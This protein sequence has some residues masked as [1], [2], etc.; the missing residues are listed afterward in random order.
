LSTGNIASAPGP[1]SNIQSAGTTAWTGDAD[2]EAIILAA[3]GQPMNSRNASKLEFDFIPLSNQIS[4]NFIFA[5]EEYGTFQCT[6]SDAFAFLLT[7]TTTNVTTNLAVIPNTTIP[8]S[9]VTIRNAIYNTGCASANPSYFGSYYLLPQGQNPI[10]APVNFNGVT[11]PMV[12]T[13]TVIPGQTYHI[14]LVVADRS[15]NAYDSAVFLEGG[16]FDIGNIQLGQD[17]LTANG[18]ALCAGDSYTIQSGLSGPNYTYVWTKDG[19]VIPN[20]TNNTLI[21]TSSGVYGLSA[22]YTGTTCTTSDAVTIQ[23]YPQIIAPTPNN[24][25][26]CN[27]LGYSEFNLATNDASSLGTLDPTAFTVSYFSSQADAVANVNSLPNLFTNTVQFSQTLYARVTNTTSGCF[28][29]N[30]FNLIVQD[31]TPQFTISPDFSICDGSTGTIVVTPIN[32]NNS[33]VIYSWTKDGVALTDT[34]NSIPISQSGVYEVTIN[35]MGCTATGTT[36]V[37]ITPIPIADTPTNV[38]VCNSYILPNLT[39]GNYYTG[40]NGSGTALNAG[41]VVSTSQVIYVFAQSGTIPNCTAQNSFTITINSITA[42]AIQNVIACTSYTL[43]SLNANNNYYT[44]TNG[45]GT[46]LAA[47]SSITNSQTL[48][49]YA[50]TGTSPNCTNESSFSITILV[51]PTLPNFNNVAACVSYVLPTLSNGNYFSQ[52]NGVGPIAQGS[53]ITT[54]QTVY[55]YSSVGTAPT[56]C[57]AEKQFDVTITNSPIFTISGECV[58]TNFVLTSELSTASNTNLSY[59]WKDQNDVNL[60]TQPT[61]I[62]SGNGNYSLVVQVIGTNCSR[63]ETF[64]ANETA[65]TI[66]KGISPNNDGLNDTFDLTGLGIKELSIY[67]RYGTKVYNKSN[68]SNEWFG[69]TNSGKELPDGTYYYVTERLDGRNDSGWIYISREIK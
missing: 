10:G 58:G 13:S 45:T 17:F 60:G 64:S 3:T 59:Q 43:P 68:Y 47:G 26:A 5:S 21:V 31:L 48:Y 28:V 52:S 61:Q 9:V 33:D 44:G 29:V 56:I 41:D 46:Q 53:A 39:N 34:T 24:L 32:Y 11:I 22:S 18:T 67:N 49:V 27:S 63:T 6:F 12:A 36:T 1:N 66:Q 30:S 20:E 54:S 14:K 65:C 19:V 62:I 2:L 38:T 37:T 16:S 35:N 57:F 15:D 25:T 8:I 4:F 23:F 50:Q 55:V 69:Q 40:I 7:N 42:Q 51:T